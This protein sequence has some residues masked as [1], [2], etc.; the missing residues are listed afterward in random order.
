MEA[1]QAHTDEVCK[2]VASML[3]QN[4]RTV[5]FDDFRSL[6][7][8]L[9]P[10]L[11]LPDLQALWRCFDK[12]G[13]GGVTRQEFLKAM[14]PSA[15]L[16]VQ[17]VSEVCAQVGHLLQREGTTVDQLFDSL[18]DHQ[19]LHWEAFAAFFQG[20]SSSLSEQ[21]LHGLW[22]SFD[23]EPKRPLN[24]Q[25]QKACATHSL[26]VLVAFQDGD[27]TVSR[28]EFV[29][30]LAPSMPAIVPCPDTALA[31][32]LW[33]AIAEVAT[34]RAGSVP[35]GS[36]ALRN[37]IR[38]QLEAFDLTR[39]GFMDPRTF[40][41]AMRAYSPALPDPVVEVLRGQVCQEDGLV[42][43]DRLVDK[44][45]QPPE[46]PRRGSVAPPKPP[47]EE[48]GGALWSAFRR[49]RPAL[50][51]RSLKLATVFQWVA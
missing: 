3:F 6:F 5:A 50:H 47:E 9:E 18:A 26:R 41:Q 42:P 11:S 28:E 16:V 12:D 29:K 22:H 7:Q 24:P 45:L 8:Q 27:G 14:E 39:T 35:R 51:E 1:A 36:A 21:D 33:Q 48:A 32:A 40:S 13:D 23:K 30:A 37:S 15:K 34:L 44:I 49:I 17:R 25:L 38:V 46:L 31:N 19:V 10:S 2:R 4:G 43:V 20:I